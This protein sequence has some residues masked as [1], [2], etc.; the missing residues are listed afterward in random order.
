[1]WNEVATV[2]ESRDVVD[3]IG[4][5]SIA[6]GR[7]YVRQHGPGSYRFVRW[8]VL[9][10]RGEI[11]TVGATKAFVDGYGRQMWNVKCEVKCE[12]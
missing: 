11:A 12:M 10:R 8:K 9:D 5:E 6:T 2:G 3:G 7:A 4:R 1:M